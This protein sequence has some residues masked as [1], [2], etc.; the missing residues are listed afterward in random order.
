MSWYCLFW[1]LRNLY[2]VYW[3]FG[4]KLYVLWCWFWFEVSKGLVFFCFLFFIFNNKEWDDIILWLEML[5]DDVWGL[6]W[7]GRLLSFVVYMEIEWYLG[8]DG[9]I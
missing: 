2:N 1:V 9:Y 8:R 6:W 5:I 4:V 3:V 7:L